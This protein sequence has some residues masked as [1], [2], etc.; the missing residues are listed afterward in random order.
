[1]SKPSWDECRAANMSAKEAAEAMGV[2]KFV[3]YYR[4]LS[5]GWKWRD[6]R[7]EMARAR[8]KAMHQ[9][10][11]FAAAHS[12]RA[13]ARFTALHKNPEFA[14]ARDARGSAQMK[15]L[16]QDPAFNPLVLL[17]PAERA[18]YDR[19][20]AH[21]RDAVLAAIGRADLIKGAKE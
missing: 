10:P 20:I 21:P 4:A 3:A 14:K 15:A 13:V 12:A 1:M 5:G 11:A 18:E 9:D 2:A 6:T 16:H 7:S 8:M 17:S 19:M